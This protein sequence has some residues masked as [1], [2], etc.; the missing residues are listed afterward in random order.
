MSGGFFD[1][2]QYRIGNIIDGIEREINRQ[3]QGLNEYLTLEPAT[4]D[5]F[6]DAVY[7][8]KVAQIYAQRVDWLLSGDDGETSFHNRLT[9]DLEELVR[10]YI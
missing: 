6:R 10:E 8:L 4:L 1:Y 3:E 7:Y 5:K 9:Q 2:D